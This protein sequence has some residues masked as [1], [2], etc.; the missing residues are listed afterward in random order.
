MDLL[1]VYEQFIGPLPEF[2]LD[3]CREW[4]KHFPCIYDTRIL[5]KATLEQIFSK[6]SK[7]KKYQGHLAFAYDAETN[8]QFAN[9][10]T[11]A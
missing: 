10:E 5:G 11:H 4:R 8:E 2:F 6:I 7:D 9:Y 3:F 1:F